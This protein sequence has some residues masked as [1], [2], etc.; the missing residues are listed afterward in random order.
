MRGVL[1]IRLHHDAAGKRDQKAGYNGDQE[2]VHDSLPSNSS[3]SGFSYDKCVTPNLQRRS[4]SG[5][6]SIGEEQL[7]T[8]DTVIRDGLLA[9]R[10]D[11]PVNETLPLL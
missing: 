5:L 3:R 11:Q 2:R 6:T 8:A 7:L 10:R 4:A 9:L 1:L